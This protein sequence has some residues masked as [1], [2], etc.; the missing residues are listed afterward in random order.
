MVKTTVQILTIMVAV[1]VFPLFSSEAKA[2]QEKKAGLLGVKYGGSD[3]SGL[4]RSRIIITSVDKEWTHDS[5][6]YACR[7]YGF[8]V[9]PYD[10]SGSLGVPG[11]FDH[12]LMKEVNFSVYL[13][14]KNLDILD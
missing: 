6:D 9:G 12:S 5:E 11:Q 2:E 3:F 8:I 1:V 7:W 13:V 10:L 14:R 4:G